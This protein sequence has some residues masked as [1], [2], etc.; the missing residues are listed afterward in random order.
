[1]QI[2]Q[3]P[4]YA[5][6][7]VAGVT[8]TTGGIAIDRMTRVKSESGGIIAGLYA[9]GSCTGGHE[10]GPYS[11]YTGGLGKALT[12]GFIAGNT[13]ARSNASAAA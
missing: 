8:Y 10:G 6:P 4:F 7:L 11:G 2:S 3:P 12:F 1:M 5:V 13:I 9:A